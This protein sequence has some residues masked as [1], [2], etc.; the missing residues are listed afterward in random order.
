MNSHEKFVKHVV[1]KLE[2]QAKQHPMQQ[3]VVE[4]VMLSIQHKTY[5]KPQSWA[6]GG[7]ALAAALTAISFAPDLLNNS[8]K[9]TS[10]QTVNNVKLSPQMVEDLE[11]LSLLGMEK[12]NYGS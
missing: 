4:Q 10:E 2:Q 5:H 1:S 8:Q 12:A 3:Q 6:L 9:I 7:L 11:M